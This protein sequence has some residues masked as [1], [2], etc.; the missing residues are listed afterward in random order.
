MGFSST[1][2]ALITI[3]YWRQNSELNTVL[4]LWNAQPRNGDAVLHRE[5][6]FYATYPT[7]FPTDTWASLSHGWSTPDMKM[8]THLHLASGLSRRRTLSSTSQTSP[9]SKALKY[10]G[11]K[12]ILHLFYTTELHATS[13]WQFDPITCQE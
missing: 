4:K 7:S 5:K 8:T 11:C 2:K 1:F 3:G 10:Y 13:R 12:S 6:Y 9:C